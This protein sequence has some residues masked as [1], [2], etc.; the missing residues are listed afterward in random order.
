LEIKIEHSSIRGVNRAY[1][2]IYVLNRTTRF[3][4]AV[5]DSVFLTL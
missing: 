2:E 4:D 5:K 1:Q 3:K